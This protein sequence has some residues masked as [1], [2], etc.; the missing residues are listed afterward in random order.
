MA[1]SFISLSSGPTKPA[2]LNCWPMNFTRPQT[3]LCKQRKSTAATFRGREGDAFCF[4]IQSRLHIKLLFTHAGIDFESRLVK[5]S[6]YKSQGREP[7]WLSCQ[8]VINEVVDVVKVKSVQE[9][10]PSAASVP[11]AGP[12]RLTVCNGRL[13]LAYCISESIDLGGGIS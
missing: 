11:A 6:S 3:A 4:W 8:G 1:A 2:G 10:A 7:V 12:S 9:D 5:V 13:D